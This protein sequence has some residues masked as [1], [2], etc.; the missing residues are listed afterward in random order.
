MK[1]VFVKFFNLSVLCLGLWTMGSQMSG[2]LAAE[3]VFVPNFFDPSY[4]LAKP[5]MASIK[6]IRF[7]TEDDFPPF[8]FTTAD[9][10]LTGFDVEIARAICEEL[11]LP[12]TIQPRRFE[13]LLEALVA[14]E[15]DA[16]I[17]GI[18]KTAQTRAKIEFSAPYY[19]TPARFVMATTTALADATPELLAGKM[20]GAEKNSAH[21]AY[22]KAFFPRSMLKSFDG[23]DAVRAALKRG[24][25]EVLFG[26]GVSLSFWLNGAEAGQC[27]RFAGG[28]FTE[29][30]YFG[31]GVSIGLRREDVA[32][33]GA[34]NYALQKITEKGLY[35]DLYLKYFPVGF[36]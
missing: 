6:L 33:R 8:H 15:G 31:E 25:I 35:T 34:I 26:D 14:G 36:Y 2:C 11:K 3:D 21:E 16:L 30:A 1:N 24:E 5:E 4:R 32:L 22:L 29:S 12:C 7:L 17:A 10:T 23:R 9:G 20:I 13:S 18:A 19:R 28:P 27:C